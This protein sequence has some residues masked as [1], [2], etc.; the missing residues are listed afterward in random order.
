MNCMEAIDLIPTDLD[1]ILLWLER[2]R[3]RLHLMLVGCIPCDRFRR[4][5]VSVRQAPRQY[6]R[7]VKGGL[8]ALR[9]Y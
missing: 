3:L 4:Q 5:A 8:E 7:R 9:L 6:A 2:L 1:H